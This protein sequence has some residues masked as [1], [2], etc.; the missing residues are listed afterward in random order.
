ML[1]VG[2]G[3][4]KV[5]RLVTVAIGEDITTTSVGDVGEA[6]VTDSTITVVIVGLGNGVV[7]ATARVGMITSFTS[8]SIKIVQAFKR[9]IQ[10][11]ISAKVRGR[12]AFIV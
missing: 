1:G 8:S 7:V 5:A 9:N 6:V 4:G 10:T 3:A 11:L 12:L 2:V